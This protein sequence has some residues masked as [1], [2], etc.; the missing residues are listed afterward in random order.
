MITIRLQNDHCL[1]L[2]FPLYLLVDI[3]LQE[4]AFPPPH[5]FIFLY[6][7]ISMDP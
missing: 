6:A 1:T 5:V 4:R 2:S 7:S 3:L